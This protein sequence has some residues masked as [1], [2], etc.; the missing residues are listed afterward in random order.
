MQ[1]V[2]DVF[3][4]KKILENHR[5]PFV[6]SFLARNSDEAIIMANNIGYPVALK[7]VS[8]QAVHKTD[9]G[10]VKLNVVSD[11]EVEESFKQIVNSVRQ[12]VHGAKISGVLVQKMIDGVQTIVGG[13]TDE[14]FGHVMLFGLGG[15]FVEVL[16]DSSFRVVPIN[17][18]DAGEMILETKA[19]KLLSDFR[20]K[21]YD[22]KAVEEI[23]LRVSKLL[24]KNPK[25]VEFDINPLMVLTKG[26]VA[27]DARIVLGE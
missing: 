17:K 22:V 25:I 7:V 21:K 10:A 2:L 15:I 5:I 12:K 27:V 18:L 1:T 26:A 4:S 9:L 24:Q 13:K 14:T 23:L 6:K 19:H 20:G 8:S 3:Q 11:R 16:E